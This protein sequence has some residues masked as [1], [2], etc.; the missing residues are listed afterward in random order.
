MNIS[1]ETSIT[2]TEEGL[3]FRDLNKNGRLDPY[4]DPRRP[5]GERVEDLLSQMTLAEKVGLMFQPMINAGPNG[6]LTEVPDMF[7]PL[8]TSE[9]IINRHIR[10][11][12][13]VFSGPPENTA[14]WYNRLQK[15]AEDTRLGIPVTI[16]TD[17]RHVATDNPGAGMASPEFS[18][19]PDPLGLAATRDAA[20]VQ[21][22]GDIARQEY[23]AVGIRAALHPMADLATEPRWGRMNGTFGEDAELSK[24]M[25]AAYIRGFQ[26]PEIGAESVSCM[27]K[28]FPGGGPQEDGW[29]AHFPYGRD[30]IYP[31]DNF[32]YHMIPFEG[33]FAAGVEQVM[34]YYGVPVGQTSED[35]GMG[36]NKEIVTNLL[37]EDRN[38]DGIVCT[39]WMIFESNEL[40]G[41]PPM[42]ESPSWGVE[43]LTVEERYQ[44]AIEAGVDQ[45]G[46]Q[47]RPQ[48]VLNLVEN[49]HVSE[50]RIDTSV[51]RILRLK[52]KLGLFDNPYVDDGSAASA[53]GTPEFQA[54]GESAQ[55]K[56]VVLLKNGEMGEGK[57][58]P[59]NG[60]PKLYVE[61]IAPETA[62]RYG[63]LVNTPAEADFA[64]LRLATPYEPPR[65]QSM[66]ENFFHQGDLDFK[67]P[68]KER[69]LNIL[70]T[71]PTIVDIYLE[72]A[73]VIPEIAAAS[74][75]L[76]GTFSVAD[77]VVLD[78][79]FGKFSPSGKLP[80]ELPSSMDAVRAQKEDL[81]CDSQDP[82]FPFGHGLQY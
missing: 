42:L 34:P 12:N 67:S 45:F 30:Q 24:E 3:R 36:F 66:L 8:S 52:F 62:A 9:M 72:R 54:A 69:I 74:A 78:A 77:H 59:L 22:F 39:D 60:R 15:M 7:N 73:A 23:L 50:E 61:N 38:F 44:K 41:T 40:P 47:L 63:D 10:H 16:S 31:G 82:L 4:E 65:G 51:R 11:C 21:Q 26:G 55:R 33:A 49:G 6:E 75:A 5:I 57:V 46:G 28:H 37:R 17:P 25:I 48:P 43:H 53:V 64:I 71:T 32:D 79:I 80:I 1:K 70:N 27:V 56:S 14:V 68:E 81:P 76:F 13:I 18:H 19:W 29:D 20:V 35:V 2:R 58:L